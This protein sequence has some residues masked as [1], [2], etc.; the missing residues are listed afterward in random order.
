MK[1]WELSLPENPRRGANNFLGD[2]VVAPNGKVLSQS[3]SYQSWLNADGTTQHSIPNANGALERLEVSR[4]SRLFAGINPAAKTA[5]IRDAAT[6]AVIQSLAGGD[7]L[8]MALCFSP[9]SDELAIGCESGHL[10]IFDYLENRQVARVSL[11]E[12]NAACHTC[13]YSPDGK[14]LVVAGK[15][16]E[17]AVLDASTYEIIERLIVGSHTYDLAFDSAGKTLA[18]A[19]DDSSIRLWNWPS[20]IAKSTLVGHDSH[21]DAITFSPDGRTL[22]STGRDGT[23]RMWS[24]SLARGLGIMI[25][26]LIGT[27]VAFSKDGRYL[28]VG[29]GTDANDFWMSTFSIQ[30]DD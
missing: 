3:L 24:T 25:D 23:L 2:L 6:G 19:H 26:N 5:E 28:Y 1:T 27:D 11:S 10:L 17:I 18:S 7:D 13:H 15:F 22:L 29:D 20:G 14:T 8:P 16:G 21:V 4:D 30:F 9:V 12:V